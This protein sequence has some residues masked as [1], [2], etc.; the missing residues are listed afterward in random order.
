M[1]DPIVIFDSVNTSDNNS[2]WGSLIVAVVAGIGLYF[3]LR[4]KNT[5]D[6]YRRQMLIAMLAFFA[7]IMAAGTAFFSFWSMQKTGPVYVY[8]NSIVTPYG[9]AKYANISKAYIEM[10]NQQ[11]LLNPGNTTSS[12]RMLFLEE[13]DGKMHVLSEDNYEIDK[14]LKEI[15]TQASQKKEKE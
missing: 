13:R 12:V 4:Q 11:A 3:I 9:E 1:G 15:R 8:E 10:N 2:F 5:G 14:I 7:M 6:A